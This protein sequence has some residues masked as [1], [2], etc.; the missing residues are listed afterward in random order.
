MNTFRLLLVSVLLFAFGTTFAEGLTRAEAEELFEQG[1]S[2]FRQANSMAD[3]DPDASRKLMQKALLRFQR[4]VDEGGIHNGR[5]YYN[6][7][8]TQYHLDDLG[9][10]ILSYRRAQT[11]I[12]DDPKLQQNLAYARSQRQDAFTEPEQRKIMK[13]MLF[14][15]YDFTLGTRSTL[16]LVSFVAVWLLLGARLFLKSAWFTRLAVVAGVL[17]LLMFGSVLQTHL[18]QQR[19]RAGVILARELVARLSDSENADPAFTE[20]L[21]AGTE[22]ELVEDRGSWYEV[23]LSDGQTCWLPADQVGL[24]H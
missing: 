4:L 3:E 18:A 16:F 17:A 5:L 10:A 22:F 6:I 7:G 14:W 24:V 15:H 19:S 21:H 23:R 1:K 13:M 11:Y 2:F 9:G 8:N 20:P 12:P